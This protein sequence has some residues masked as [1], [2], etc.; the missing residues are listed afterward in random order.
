MFIFLWLCMNFAS[1]R[2]S[3]N[4]DKAEPAQ[5]QGGKLR[6]SPMRRCSQPMEKSR[7]ALVEGCSAFFGQAAI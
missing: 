7:F 4:E 3:L 5:D 2:F 1:L 6:G